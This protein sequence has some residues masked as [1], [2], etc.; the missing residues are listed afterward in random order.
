MPAHAAPAG[1]ALPTSEPDRPLRSDAARSR[2][3]LI[4]AAREVFAS[5]GLGAGLNEIAH[6]AGV[7]VGTAY[8]HFPDKAALIDAALRDRLEELVAMAEAG[9]AAPVAWDGLTDVLRQMAA[10]MVSDIGLRDA[11]LSAGRGPEAL[12]EI[13]GRMAPLLTQLLARAQAAGAARP[14]ITVADLLV[15]LLLVTEFAQRSAPV[16][17]QSHLRYLELFV[18]ALRPPPDGATLGEPLSHPD[19]LRILMQPPPT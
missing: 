16:A 19:L 10:A 17:P 3:R 5:R 13:D 9:L 14:D 11:A 8:R 4:V 2:Q 6:H 7:G 15:T 18:N 1:D 12:Q